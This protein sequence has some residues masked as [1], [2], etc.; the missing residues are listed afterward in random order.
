MAKT[1]KISITTKTGD[2]GDTRLFSGEKVRKNSARLDAYGDLDELVSILS[3]ARHHVSHKNLKS[4]ILLLQRQLFTVGAELA[5]T[6]G[7][8]N[9]LKQRVDEEMLQ[10][11]ENKRMALEEL[12]EIPRGFVIP[13]N[14]QASA[15]LD[16]ARTIARR[17]ERKAVALFN[18]RD[19]DN[20]ILLIWLNRLSDYLYLMARSEEKKS[21]LVKE[22]K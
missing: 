3:V 13:G 19:L 10:E 17:C 5:T 8:L 22:R 7:K 4:D 14:T 20:K 16:C 9:R 11:M 1:T 15:Y 18:N 12:V 21:L 6:R 2:Q